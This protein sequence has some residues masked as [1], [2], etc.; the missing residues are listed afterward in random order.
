MLNQCNF[1]GRLGRDVEKR[2]LQNGD[3]VS[4]FSLAVSEKWTSK[5]GEK[6][7]KTEWVK[8]VCYG[9]LADLASQYIGKGSLVYVSGKMQTRTWDHEGEKKYATE[10]ILKD[11]KFLSPKKEAKEPEP[12]EEEELNPIGDD[13]NPELPF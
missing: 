7:E 4:T 3:A 13:D 1:I 2:Y 10:I 9:K 12:K 6:K 5:E 8:C 11:I